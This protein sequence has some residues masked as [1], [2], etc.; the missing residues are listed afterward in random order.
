MRV[1]YYLLASA[2]CLAVVLGACSE[3]PTSVADESADVGAL[4]KKE[5]VNVDLCHATHYTDDDVGGAFEE[6]D[7]A[8]VWISV[9]PRAV[10]KHM[11][12]H[13]DGERVGGTDE[14]LG[15]PPP[16]SSEY[17]DR[18]DD[19][20]GVADADDNCVETPNNAQDN[21]DGD[22]YGDA[23]D[24]CPG[25]ANDLQ[26]DADGDG[27]G[28][29]CDTCPNDADNDIDGDGVCGDVDN[30]PDDANAGQE[31]VDS[32]GLGDACDACTDV[33][34]DGYCFE[35]DDCDDDDSAV[36][37]G[38][39]EDCGNGVDDDCNGDV[40]GDDAFCQI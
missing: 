29:A 39:T 32:D 11:D 10:D 18:D 40:D 5:G 28:D 12:K 21:A 6:G 25:I 9:D 15:G 22:L 26:E 4:N 13:G 23:C 36:N 38:A 24:N 31:D 16:S 3:G 8:F 37:P 1:P 19:V 35:V 17:C 27:I 14:N 30:C 34:G 7:D 33:D 2:L 20:D